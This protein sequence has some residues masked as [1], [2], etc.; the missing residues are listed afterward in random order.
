MTS[1]SKAWLAVGTVLVVL[2]LG[3]LAIMLGT[4]YA[5]RHV[6]GNTLLPSRSRGRSRR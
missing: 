4:R 6:P 5:T 1:R 2:G 3:L